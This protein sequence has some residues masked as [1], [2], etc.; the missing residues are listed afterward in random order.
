MH[1]IGELEEYPCAFAGMALHT[2]RT[3]CEQGVRLLV[4]LNYSL[5]VSQAESMT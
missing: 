5:T 4:L 2:N 3:F 1:A